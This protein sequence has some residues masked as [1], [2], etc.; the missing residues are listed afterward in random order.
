VIRK[1]D[2]G[3]AHT[4]VRGV[5]HQSLAVDHPLMRVRSR[6]R[7]YRPTWAVITAESDG[8]A[9]IASGGSSVPQLEPATCLLPSARFGFCHRNGGP[10]N[11]IED[12]DD[13]I[14]V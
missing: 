12:V 4:D 10:L 13:D 14:D 8:P 9:V 11:V 1:L 6:T 5:V 2:I 3:Q 7:H